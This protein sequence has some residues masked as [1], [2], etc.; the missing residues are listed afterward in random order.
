M[1]P[2]IPTEPPSPWWY[3]RRAVYVSRR[4]YWHIFKGFLAFGLPLAA[5]GLLPGLRPLFHAAL[6]MAGVGLLLLIYSLIGLYRMYGHPARAYLRRLL[7]LAG[8]HGPVV[9][10]D[11]H[12]GTYRHSYALADLL[13]EALIQSVDV[14]DIEG[15][16]P[17]LAVQD[18]RA[19]EP[20]PVGHPRIRPWRARGFALPLADASCDAVVFGFGT[21]EIPAGPARDT[22]F[23]EAARVLKP[24]GRVLMFE[25]GY[26]VHNYL[27]FGPVI[28]HVTRKED[29]RA[30]LARHF[31]D[32]RYARSGHA[33]DLYAAVRRG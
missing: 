10:A 29:W 27:I 12:I 18:V 31:D 7:G 14:W 30:G 2:A 15:P 16:P 25:H 9:V 19:L 32:V 28:G 3:F 17:E 26:D 23:R 4:D 13:P 21:H 5:A 22:L 6:F 20:A 11:V 33:V 8:L 24:A 1:I